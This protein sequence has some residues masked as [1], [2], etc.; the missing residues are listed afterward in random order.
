M[1]SLF[2]IYVVSHGRPLFMTF[3]HSMSMA[4]LWAF[5][6]YREHPRR[7]NRYVEVVECATGH[8]TTM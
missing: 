1:A 6:F 4:R 3:V 7:W 2:R 5:N 8:V